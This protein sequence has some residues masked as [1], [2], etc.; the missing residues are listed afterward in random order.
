[1][2]TDAQG[3]ALTIASDEAARAFDHVMDG[4]IRPRFDAGAR[5]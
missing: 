3:N 4:F 1:M 5:L 2:P